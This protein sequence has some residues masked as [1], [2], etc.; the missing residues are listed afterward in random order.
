MTNCQD[1]LAKSLQSPKSQIS[2][3]TQKDNAKLSID[4]K[5]RNQIEDIVTVTGQ[6][7]D[8]E[9]SQI[10]DELRSMPNRQSIDSC[11]QSK[12]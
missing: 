7:I 9:F 5:H 2:F 6:V 8:R 4:I 3:V 11:R 1:E 12:R 10:P